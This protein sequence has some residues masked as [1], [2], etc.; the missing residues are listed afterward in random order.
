MIT[1]TAND[2][3]TSHGKMSLQMCQSQDQYQVNICH[4]SMYEKLVTNISIS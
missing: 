2:D 3:F 1:S 4:A